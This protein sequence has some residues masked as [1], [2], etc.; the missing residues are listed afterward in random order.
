MVYFIM[1]LK[2]AAWAGSFW[3]G[4]RRGW[5]GM[6]LWAAGISIFLTAADN[7]E[8]MGTLSV[9]LLTLTVYALM[10]FFL[11]PLA[12]KLKNP[13]V[14]MACNVAGTYGAFAVVNLTIDFLR[15]NFMT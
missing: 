14:S 10:S 7:L 3:Y 2:T 13:A 8:E 6:L 11:I 15:S 5:K 4:I 1:F 12:W 9:L